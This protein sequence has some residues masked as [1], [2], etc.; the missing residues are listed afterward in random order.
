MAV[1]SSALQ[2]VEWCNPSRS[3]YIFCCSIAIGRQMV[4]WC[5]CECVCVC[6]CA[7]ACV[8][9]LNQPH[10]G[11]FALCSSLSSPPLLLS[12]SSPLGL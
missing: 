10:Q 2:A 4:K 5:A 7:G 12:S 1:N 11:A 3:C 9:S 8:L 6:V